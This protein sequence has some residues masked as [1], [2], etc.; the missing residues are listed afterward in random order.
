MKYIKNMKKL[1]I[2]SIIPIILVSCS[3]ENCYQTRT[4]ESADLKYD[5]IS[6]V[7]KCI[8]ITITQSITETQQYIELFVIESMKK[9]R[10]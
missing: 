5:S 6:H 8:K 3:K 9:N 7:I 1:L 2:L 4:C 10:L